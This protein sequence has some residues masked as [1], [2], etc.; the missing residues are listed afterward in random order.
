MP[1]STLHLTNAYHAHSGGIRT[2]YHALMR[3]AE[4]EGR[5][6]TLVVPGAFDDV[7]VRG[8]FTRVIY[9]RAPRSPVV[10]RRYRVLLPH[11]F[12]AGGR[13]PLWR[14]LEQER[15]DVVEV[16]D[17]YSLCYFAGLIR[18]R[19][20]ASGPTL[21]GLSCERLDDNV[22]ALTAGS[23]I[24]SL[25]SHAYLGR[26]YIGMFDEHIANSAYTAQELLVAM[27]APHIRPVHVCPMGVD[28]LPAT[29]PRRI[30]AV[31]ADLMARAG[32]VGAHIVVYAGRLSAEKQVMLLPEV[33]AALAR[34]SRPVR[35]VVAGDGPLRQ[36]LNERARALAPGRV[37]FVGH[38]ADRRELAA[39]L[40]AADVFLHPNGREPFGIGPLE[41]MSAGTAVVAP[42][43][44]GVLSYASNENAWLA[45][46]HPAALAR[47]V[48]ACL[49]DHAERRRRIAVGRLTAESHSWHGAATRMLERYDLI[50]ANRLDGLSAAPGRRAVPTIA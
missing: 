2:M 36:R 7:D 14:L 9:I 48:S 18:R 23:R 5:R 25:A 31:R 20:G 3:Q 1:N 43:S 8:P 39:L 6:L 26:V 22:Q 44:G 28:P 19:R 37:H 49:D 46:Q 47:A 35:L 16:C 17:K 32:A 33:I 13:G 12:L 15:P 10:D 4:R 30:A 29:D 21:V 45:T 41:A 11:R 42:G 40:G 50:H 27:R 38:L 24:A 34:R